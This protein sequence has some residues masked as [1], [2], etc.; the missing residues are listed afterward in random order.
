M[1]AEVVRPATQTAGWLQDPHSTELPGEGGEARWGA[2]GNRVNESGTPPGGE[3]DT[4]CPA[5]RVPTEM[6]ARP[7]RLLVDRTGWRTAAATVGVHKGSLWAVAHRD[8]TVAREVA[9]RIV[10]AAELLE[11]RPQA[12][13]RLPF[14]PLAAAAG[15][16]PRSRLR[17]AGSGL[18]RAWDRGKDAG[19]LSVP[20]ADLLAVRFLRLHPWSVWGDLWL[21]PY[22]TEGR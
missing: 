18:L 8:A 5:G 9:T 6:I 7:L 22:V 15:P 20:A 10:L 4:R 19:C 16:E 21:M 12:G 17:A 13:L 11:R 14:A 3:P 1:S 2:P